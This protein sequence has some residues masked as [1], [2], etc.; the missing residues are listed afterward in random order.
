MDESTVSTTSSSGQ[1]VLLF[2]VGDESGALE[3]NAVDRVFRAVEL[4]KLPDM[5]EHVEGL[6]NLNGDALPV[7]SMRNKFGL[8]AREIDPD[9][10]LIIVHHE[11]GRFVIRS[12]VTPQIKYSSGNFKEKLDN[13]HVC[14]EVLHDVLNIDGKLVPLYNPEQLLPELDLKREIDIKPE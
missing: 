9:D 2:S 10:F 4:V 7:I 8:P 14:N 6:L 3:L 1:E 5:P 11:S 13:Y 12:E